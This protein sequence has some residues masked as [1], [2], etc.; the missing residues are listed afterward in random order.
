MMSTAAE[1]NT[2]VGLAIVNGVLLVSGV[3]PGLTSAWPQGPPSPPASQPASLRT[4][5][6]TAH[7]AVHVMCSDMF[8]NVLCAK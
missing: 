3:G 7:T 4:V 5:V 8:F 2:V 6:P 1:K